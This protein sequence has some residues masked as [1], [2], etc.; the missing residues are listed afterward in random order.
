MKSGLFVELHVIQSF[1]PSNLNRDDVGA[2]KSC[3]FGGV[4]RARISSQCLKRTAREF[5]RDMGLL[6]REVLAERS[7]RFVTVKLVG[8]VAT[9]NR[10]RD[11][12]RAVVEAAL[13]GGDI[14]VDKDHRTEYLLYLGERAVSGL[15]AV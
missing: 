1:A 6:E 2:P 10:N 3:M 5:V 8:R 7:R 11:D 12:A 9:A 4:P 13:R 14:K 15:T